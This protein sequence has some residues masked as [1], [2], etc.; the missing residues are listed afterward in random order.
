MAERD[1]NNATGKTSK[2]DMNRRVVRMMKEKEFFE[3]KA[4]EHRGNLHSKQTHDKLDQDRKH[5][6]EKSAHA[7]KLQKDYG[8]QKDQT[9]D[10]ITQLKT[11]AEKTRLTQDERERG[12]AL[13]KNLA[14]IQKREKEQRD[15]LQKK[16]A[17]EKQTLAEK[18]EDQTKRAEQT[19]NQ[20][21][22]N[23]QIA[24]WKPAPVVF[25]ETTVQE[26]LPSFQKA[27]HSAQSGHG[28]ETAPKSL[29][30]APQPVLAPKGARTGKLNP[31]A[32]QGASAG[33][34]SGKGL[35]L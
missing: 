21:R 1:F 10:E 28:E 15:G 27:A 24:G 18:H 22:Q 31:S 3:E 30:G 4:G 8:D 14:D 16:Q 13:Q 35:G 26:G 2:E 7:D 9:E 12:R 20:A 25:D 19:I 29:S 34:G 23:R 17:E 6:R 33:K 5:Q 11:K 32:E